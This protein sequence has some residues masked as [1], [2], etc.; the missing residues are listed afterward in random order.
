MLFL[1][2]VFAGAQAA[3]RK[4]A[5]F[6]EYEMARE[7]E[8]ALARSAAPEHISRDATIKVLTRGGFETAIK[9]NNGFVCMVM[10]SWSAAPDLESSYYAKI[11]SPICFDAI[12]ARTVAPAEELRTKL[13][14]EGKDPE[15]IAREVAVRYGN[16]QLPRMESTAFGY[17]WSASQNTGPGFGAWHPHM[18]VYAPYYENATLGGNEMG[19]H[20]A[21]FVAG[22]GT[23][24]STV[25]IVV[26]D[27]L[28]IKAN[29]Q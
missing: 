28:A 13:G 12:A 25:L 8:I 11:R 29:E 23:P 3:E 14:L 7:S 10:R 1:L 20:A 22:S 18:M 17:M 27:K 5:P 2:I 19:G 4:Y 16:G 24:Y 6:G 21:P 9:G 15:T 26:D